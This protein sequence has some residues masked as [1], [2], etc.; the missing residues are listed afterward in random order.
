MCTYE[1]ENIRTGI[2]PRYCRASKLWV[3]W[4]ELWVTAL[5]VPDYG[6]NFKQYRKEKR[7]L[8]PKWPI[9]EFFKKPNW[10]QWGFALKSLRLWRRII[11]ILTQDHWD[12]VNQNYW[13]FMIKIIEILTQNRRDFNTKI[14]EILTLKSWFQSD[15]FKIST[16]NV[17]C[18]DKP[19]IPPHPKTSNKRY[20]VF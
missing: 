15:F 18:L 3:T 16:R 11:E 14:I 6:L 8:N 17:R 2:I 10:N 12:F 5:W 7:A 9:R 1:L 20:R 19:E 4:Q 13:D